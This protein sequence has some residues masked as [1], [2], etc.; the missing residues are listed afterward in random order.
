MLK[1][2]DFRSDFYS[3]P[4]RDP[5]SFSF[6]MMKIGSVALAALF[7]FSTYLFLKNNQPLVNQ[8][9]GFNACLLSMGFSVTCVVGC[10]AALV[11]LSL[12]VRELLTP[13]PLLE[14]RKSSIVRANRL[15]SG[16]SNDPLPGGFPLEVS[17]NS[18]RTSIIPLSHENKSLV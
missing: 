1:I 4:Q 10:V 8:L 2:F 15:Q 13:Q 17:S 5:S 7:S 12:Q 18:R 6:Q 3:F 16:D 14:K 9:L 11:L